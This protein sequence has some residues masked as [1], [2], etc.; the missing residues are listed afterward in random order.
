MTDFDQLMD[1]NLEEQFEGSLYP[2]VK[3]FVC[4]REPKI[5]A[6]SAKADDLYFQ[7]TKLHLENAHYAPKYSPKFGPQQNVTHL[8]QCVAD[9]VST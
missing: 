7:M 9:L 3:A 6:E 1:L 2:D 4:S 5:A 8:I